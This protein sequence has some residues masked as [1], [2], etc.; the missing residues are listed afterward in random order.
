[1]NTGAGIYTATREDK[2]EAVPMTRTITNESSKSVHDKPLTFN[3]DHIF[4]HMK[5]VGPQIAETA[6]HR[7]VIV[8][9]TPTLVSKSDDIPVSESGRE[10]RKGMDLTLKEP[11]IEHTALE[12]PGEPE[13]VSESESG[14]ISKGKEPEGRAPGSFPNTLDEEEFATLM[15]TSVQPK[16][17][18]MER[19]LSGASHFSESLIS[20]N[21]IAEALRYM[22]ENS[23][24]A[25]IRPPD[26]V[27]SEETTDGEHTTR[28]I[29]EVITPE[30]ESKFGQANHLWF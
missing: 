2:T 30:T 8:R 14:P 15:E 12:L 5:E 6:V 3:G 28:N 27:V 18:P 10:D 17:P 21:A 19:G 23:S 13:A 11:L 26:I 22:R 7:A 24:D 1:M 4:P 29:V 9:P 25:A 16:A 20:V